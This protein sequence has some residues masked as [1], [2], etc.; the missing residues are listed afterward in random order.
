MKRL[1]LFLWGI[2]VGATTLTAQQRATI[3]GQVIDAATH[4]PL[5]GANVYIPLHKQGQTTN[6]QG[7]FKLLFPVNRKIDF[8]IS[9]VGYTTREFS[10]S[11][12]NDTVMNVTLKQDNRLAEVHIYAP[13]KDFGV[14][15]PQ[16]SA[17]EMPIARI[18]Q[19]PTLFGEVDVLKALQKLPGVQSSNDGQAGVFVRGGNYD[20]NQITLDGA[21]LY[22]AEHLKGFVSAI[23][24]DMVENLIFYKG[25]FPARYGGQL[26]S[27]ID[28]GIKEGDM[29]KYH[30]ELMAGMLSAKVHIEGPILKGRTSFNVGARMSYFDAIVQPLMENIAD[31]KHSMSPYA[32]VNYYDVSAKLAHRFSEQHKIA[33]SF[34]MGRDKNDSAPT[35][36][37]QNYRTGTEEEGLTEYSNTRKNATENNWGN[38][39]SSLY[40]TYRINNRMTMNTNLAYSSYR[41]KLKYS[42]DLENIEEDILKE[43]ETV[44]G[45]ELKAGEKKTVHLKT[46]KSYSVYHSGIDDASLS[47]DFL[48]ALSGQHSLRWGAKASFYNF[49]PTVD[50]YKYLYKK[51]LTDKN[52]YRESIALTDT[53]LGKEQRMTAAS[54]Y[55]EDDW[56][57]NSHLKANIGVRYSL[58]SVTG[59]QYHSM[60]PRLSMRWLLRPDMAIKLSY[61]RMAQGIHLLSSSNLVMPSDIWVPITQEVPLMK[62]DQWAIGYN[63]EI[64][65]GV[66]L[67]VEG[68]Y[69]T[70]SNLLEYK[71]GTSYMTANGDW[72][73]LITLGEGRAYGAELLLQKKSGKTTGWLSYTWSKSLRTFDE[74]NGGREYYAGN[75][76][77]HNFNIVLTHRF[78]KHWEGSLS[79][80]Y[81]TGRRGILSTTALYGGHVDEYDPFQAA[82]DGSFDGYTAE[83]GS[84]IYFRRYTRFYTYG[85]RNDFVLPA[86]HRLDAG[87]TYSLSHDGCES[88]INLSIYNVYNR[89]NISNVYIGYDN[90]RTVLKGVCLLPFMPSLSYTLKF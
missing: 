48:A 49:T 84:S 8:R 34:Y 38:I 61:A 60:E 29:E 37:Y 65:K 68:Y 6:A 72:Q 46:E 2:I 43:N 28:I 3:T 33:A 22:N 39:V 11:V 63:Y 7:E 78:N 86:I 82:A 21:T 35:D 14:D 10:L 15:N 57:L 55:V 67:S 17:I 90:N 66:D 40:W 4:E 79:W 88:L 75:D 51:E 30:T 36:S 54:I 12:A 53:I 85:D 26:S 74:L 47:L 52:D 1:S 71:E 31:N 50:V 5:Q 9:F 69:K 24:P 76:R 80:T 16:M 23:N 56:T 32:N 19:V 13:K 25:A 77:R 45:E 41:Y 44:A 83:S 42:S 64:T 59:K 81:Q 27:V 73:E 20:Q 18:R 58:F 70:M 89:Q 62:S 87:I